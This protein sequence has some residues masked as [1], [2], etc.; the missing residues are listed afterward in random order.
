MLCWP[1]LLL[2]AVLLVWRVAGGAE[3]GQ[4][5]VAATT[6]FVFVCV[7]ISNRSAKRR[8]EQDPVP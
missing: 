1:M 7:L 2:S 6:V 8:A 3:A 5:I 4:I